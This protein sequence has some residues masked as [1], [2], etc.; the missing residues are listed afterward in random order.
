[1]DVMSEVLAGAR[2]PAGAYRPMAFNRS[3]Y[4]R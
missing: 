2:V 1:M 3:D 4:N